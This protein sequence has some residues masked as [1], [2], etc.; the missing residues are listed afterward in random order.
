M[1]GIAGYFFRNGQPAD[2]IQLANMAKRLEH[3]GPDGF[4][5]WCNGSIGL[6]HRMLWTTPES[7]LE[8]LPAVNR[9]G[10][11]VITADARIDNRDELIVQLG[12]DGRTSLITDSEVI[13]AA[14]EKWGDSSP[15]RLV[16][17]FVFVIWDAARQQLFCA[18]DPMGVKCLYYYD[19]PRLFA[20]ASEIKALASLDEIPLRLNELR[21]ADFLVNLFEDREITF[22]CDVKR[23]LGATT[24]LV[25]RDGV[26]SSRYWYL[27]P[28]REIQL[29]SD[30]EYAE[31]FRDLFGKA[32]A[33]R[34]RSVYPI[35][36][37]LSGGLDSSSIAC[38]ARQF[39]GG[40][41]AIHTLS[42][43]FPGLPEADRKA[44]D[45][46]PYMN[47]ALATGNFVPHSIQADRLSPLRDVSR[48]HYHLDEA[49]FAPNLYLHWAMYEEAHKY[50]IRVVLDG[51][52][53]DTTVCHGLTRL[54]D[55]LVALRWPTLWREL[56]LMRHNL[57]PD[58][59]MAAVFFNF[60]V[61]PLAP[62]CAYRLKRVL[63]GQLKEAAGNTTLIE[64]SFMRRLD[65][66]RRSRRLL[67]RKHPWYENTRFKHMEGLN[68]ATYASAL[69]AADKS[70]AAFGLEARYPFFDRRLIEF[71]VALPAS[72]KFAGGWNRIILR[73]AMEGILPREIQ[74]RP[75]K[76]NLG[77]NFNRRLLDFDGDILQRLIFNE[78]GVVDK[79]VDTEA[80][81]D[82]YFEY[83][84]CPIGNDQHSVQ[85]F[86]A[87]N[88]ALWLR[89]GALGPSRLST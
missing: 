34:M 16:G 1:S 68:D 3:R 39:A 36:C 64:R 58:A 67:R 63:R 57:M 12:I 9:S 75:G 20:F 85:L 71:C 77:L 43:V 83:Q 31:A 88:L 32:V 46:R 2:R 35:A 86:T 54:P 61:K 41:E 6:A 30:G 49:N 70:T 48:V 55:L 17:D 73:R 19:S 25:T 69:E 22:Y 8:R 82:A 11:L 24:L 7:L 38:M 13:L 33:S 44:I 84:R 14:Y 53:G 5:L 79:Y 26:K 18:R 74:W 78:A 4:D 59:S 66:R 72:Q 89:D 45:E 65:M 47:A 27:D 81:R 60:C 37:T 40:S 80:M 56:V 76:G 52:D 15:E 29:S 21:V 50:G 28:L 10:S 87:A 42:A 51:F 62:L 23:M